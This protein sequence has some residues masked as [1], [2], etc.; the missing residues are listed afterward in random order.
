MKGWN[1]L[2][3]WAVIA[4]ALAFACTT[5][6][7]Q[8]TLKP[9]PLA[10]DSHTTLTSGDGASFLKIIITSHGNIRYLESPAGRKH[11][12]AEG[13]A[14]VAGAWPCAMGGTAYDFG[15]S[16][17]RWIGNPTIAQPNGKNTLPLAVT[18][19]AD[20][21]SECGP[22]WNGPYRL[23]LKQVFDRYSA[24][25]EV[26]V[27]MT[28]KNVGKIPAKGVH[29]GRWFDGDV[30]SST[31]NRY[32]ATPDSVF[33]WRVRLDPLAYGYG[34]SL[35]SLTTNFPVAADM[36]RYT[37]RPDP[38][39]F[40]VWDLGFGIP[41]DDDPERGDLAGILTYNLGDIPVGASKTVKMVY[42]RF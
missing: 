22:P 18:R 1:T 33:A 25:R 13:Y 41:N 20:F 24:E 21:H 42:R 40:Q 2:E 38:D 15:A 30:D 35:T 32:Y 26:T 12:Y 3:K 27:T 6:F 37:W 17:A 23:E 19:R 9:E 14:L 36:G 7:A 8:L 28:V 5:A 39:S 10:V 31:D 34:L 29:L 4:M 11:I 16:E